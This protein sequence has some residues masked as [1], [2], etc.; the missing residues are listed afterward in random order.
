MASS[1]L[2]SNR[3]DMKELLSLLSLPT[4]AVEWLVELFDAIQFFDDIADKDEVSRQRLDDVIWSLL[5]SMPSNPFYREHLAHLSPLIASQILKWQASDKA[6][7]SGKADEKSFM[8]RAGYYEIVLSVVC[9]V[10]GRKAATDASERILRL[11]GESFAE[12]K[13]EFE[14]CP[15]R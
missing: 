10:H 6:E 4:Q 13:K 12:Y 2:L 15:I 7:R 3:D 14:P 8:W 11:Y 1:G 5:V 9:L